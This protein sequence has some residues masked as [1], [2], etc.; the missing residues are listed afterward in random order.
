MT[1]ILKYKDYQGSAEVDVERGVLRGK[2][3]FVTDLV[4]YQASTPKELQA[5]FEA[6]V[7]DYVETCLAIGKEPQKCF[8]GQFNV[9]IEPECHKAAVMLAASD[10]R[11]LNA[12]VAEAIHE[13]VSARNG[14]PRKVEHV[15]RIVLEG[16][17]SEAIA[18]SS[19]PVRWESVDVQL[20]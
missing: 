18:T 7:E 14:T 5:E 6:A 17:V 4:T 9:R 12:V 8:T 20:H 13:Y 3:M 10:E 11:S 16:E 19:S 1:N 15:H 2:L